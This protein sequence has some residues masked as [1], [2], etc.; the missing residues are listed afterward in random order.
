MWSLIITFTTVIKGSR[1]SDLAKLNPKW[2]MNYSSLFVTAIKVS[3][4]LCDWLT[5][6]QYQ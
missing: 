6:L 4:D 5:L 3:S 2:D 1:S